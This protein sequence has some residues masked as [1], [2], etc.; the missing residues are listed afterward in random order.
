MN[1][2]SPLKRSDKNPVISP[3]DMPM[4][5]SAVFNPG[6][7]RFGDEVLMVLRVEDYARINHFHTARSKDGVNF[8][9]DPAELVIDL[10]DV[11]KQ[12]G[13]M[14][15]DM[16]ITPVD[17]TYLC[18][19]CCWLRGY[20][21]TVALAKTND[22]KNFE[23]VHGPTVP[24]NR[25]AVL[26]PE[27]IGGRY[28]RFER[29][30]GGRSSIWLSYSP[31]LVHWGDAHPVDVPV[32]MWSHGKIGGGAI[33]IR[34]DKGWLVIYHAVANPPPAGNYFL[35]AMLLDAENPTTI[36]ACP[37]KFILAPREPYELAGQVPNVVF[38]GGAVQM[39]D[40]TLNVYYGAADTCVCVAQTTVDDLLSFCLRHG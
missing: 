16:R 10:S 27:K 1:D 31:D 18:Y 30:E 11:E 2:P 39:D 40:G 15:F 37:K 34:T 26:F 28:C 33:P 3:S 13:A 19:Y 8:S 22:F 21:S 38:S 20:G 23:S 35:G 25:N 4:E 12:W 17:D 6:A 32:N 5:C 14:R 24:T 7:V 29:P 9:V 36:V